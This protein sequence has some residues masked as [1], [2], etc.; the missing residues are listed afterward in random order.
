MTSDIHEG[1]LEPA[2]GPA[3][4]VAAPRLTWR[5]KRWERRRK[6]KLFEEV[7]GWILVPVILLAG[8]WAL[9]G[10]LGLFGL[11]PRAV[12]DGIDAVITAVTHKAPTP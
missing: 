5:E 4:R 8:Y 11:T 2:Q 9:T 7:L 10:V 3:Q 6:R 12:M 1:P